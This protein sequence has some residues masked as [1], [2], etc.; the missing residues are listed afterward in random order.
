MNPL[1]EHANELASLQ[2]E[3]GD[4]CPSIF[5]GGRLIKVLAGGARNANANSIGGASLDADFSGVFTSDQFPTE[6]KADELFRYP[7]ATGKR[8]KID[9]VIFA[10]G[11]KQLRITA[12]DAAQSL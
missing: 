1:S 4:D 9:A 5:Y 6:P 11:R 12:I 7:A 2:T 8:Y 10:P 3:L